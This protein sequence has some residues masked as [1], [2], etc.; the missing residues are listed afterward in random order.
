MNCTDVEAVNALLSTFNSTSSPRP[1]LDAELVVFGGNSMNREEAIR[2]LS[3]LV[4]LQQRAVDPDRLED[5]LWE[6]EDS[7]P[8]DMGLGF[9]LPHCKS[10]TL[11]HSSIAYLRPAQPFLWSAESTV[12]VRAVIMLGMRPDSGEHMQALSR[13]ARKLMDEDFRERLLTATASDT[14]MRLLS[15]AGLS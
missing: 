15:E 1:L 13:L 5:S 11:L 12:P 6:R 14:V 10:E 2:E 4:Y 7:Y 9:A 3:D 8:T